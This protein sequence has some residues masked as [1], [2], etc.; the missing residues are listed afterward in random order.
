M[1]VKNTALLLIF[2]WLGHR[3]RLVSFAFFAY[4]KEDSSTISTQ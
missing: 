1:Q 4:K 2:I 3:G